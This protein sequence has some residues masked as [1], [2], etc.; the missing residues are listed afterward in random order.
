MLD[1]LISGSSKQCIDFDSAVALLGYTPNAILDSVAQA[2]LNRDINALFATLATVFESGHN[3]LRFAQDLLQVFSDLLIV[4]AVSTNVRS[5]LSSYTNDR[6]D[7]LCKLAQ[8]TSFEEVSF[9]ADTL[10]KALTI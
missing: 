9:I 4:L 2:I 7:H 3:A 5:I 8:E 10:Q 6:F 1:Q